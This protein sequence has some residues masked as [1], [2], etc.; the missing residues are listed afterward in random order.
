MLLFNINSI[1]KPCVAPR[2]RK[3]PR[4]RNLPHGLTPAQ[5]KIYKTLLLNTGSYLVS[6]IMKNR[7]KCFRLID[8]H[9]NP[10]MNI[11]KAIVNRMINRFYLV[12]SG[13]KIFTVNKESH[14]QLIKK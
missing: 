6:H 8:V 1:D 4:M 11:N 3:L 13:D 7:K 10:L 9:C 2:F 5:K 12:K 14:L